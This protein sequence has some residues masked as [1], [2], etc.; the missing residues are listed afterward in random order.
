MFDAETIEQVVR[1]VLAERLKSTRVSGDRLKEL[2]NIDLASVEARNKVLVDNPID[3][4]ALRRMKTT[5]P[6]RIAIGRSGP[7][8]K[9]P[10]LL[11]LRADHAVARDAV[12][13]DVD[14]ALLDRLGLFSVQTLCRDRDEHLTRPDL[15]RQFAPETMAEVRSRCIA[16]PRVQIFAA[17]GLSS[18]AINANLEN[19]LSALADGL[20]RH[21]I[22]EGTR[23][24]V[25][26]GRVP[27]MDVVGTMLDAEV[28]CVLIGER[29]GL[30]NAKSMSAYICYRPEPGMPEARRTVISNIHEGGMPAVEAGAYIADVIRKMLETKTS[31]VELRL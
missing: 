3:S 31:G 14:A 8:L 5:T 17:D 30:G 21:G 2:E 12:M 10:T 27:A 11:T 29:P 1:Q 18:T 25:K 26:F 24:F 19:F 9:T 6:A 15:G 4:E 23:F 13:T 28:V 16:S 20:D 22:S 7:R